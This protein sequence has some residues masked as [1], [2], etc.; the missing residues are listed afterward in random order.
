MICRYLHASNPITETIIPA[1]FHSTYY[2]LHKHER[3]HNRN[4]P[5]TRPLLDH[6]QE[7]IEEGFR[8]AMVPALVI[9]SFPPPRLLRVIEALAIP[10][11]MA[12]K[13]RHKVLNRRTLGVVC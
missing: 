1:C 8:I 13:I 3:S 6:S 10:S 9:L 2:L 5:P 12:H 4:L 11:S 7:D